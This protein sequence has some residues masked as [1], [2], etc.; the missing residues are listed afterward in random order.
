MV[1][2]LV[3]QS[4]GWW[5]GRLGQSLRQSLDGLVGQIFVPLVSRLVGQSSQ[6]VGQ[7]VDS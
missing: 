4:V 1:S 3:G 7:W 2:C 5:V 6:L